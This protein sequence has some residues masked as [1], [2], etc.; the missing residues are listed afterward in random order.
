L[1]TNISETKASESAREIPRGTVTFLFTDIQG[2]TQLVHQYGDAYPDILNEHN[3]LL[4]AIFDSY[5]GYEVNTEGDS[6]FIAFTRAIDG[7]AAAAAAQSAL[8]D[9]VWPGGTTVQVRMGLHTGEPMCTGDD[10]TGLDVHRAARIG[11]AAHGG[12]ILASEPVKMLASSRL[13][14]GVAFRDMGDHKL[15]DLE[16]LEHLFQVLFPG[17]RDEFPPIRSLNNRPN[18]L[19]PQTPRMIGREKEL[20]AICERLRNPET[21]ILTLTGPGGTGKTLLALKAS[22]Q[23][24]EY[25]QDGVYLVELASISDT[26]LVPGEIARALGLRETSA[27][28]MIELL[29]QELGPKKALLVLD[30]L[31]QVLGAATVVAPLIE[32]CP[33]LHI[34]V[35]SRSPMHIRGETTFPVPPLEVPLIRPGTAVEAIAASPAVQLFEAR[36]AQVNRDFKLTNENSASVA[37]I[38]N[39]LG[40]LPLAIELAAARL[41]LLTPQSLLSRLVRKDDRLSLDLLAGGPHDSSARQ[42][43]IRS[44]IAWSYD[45]I[46]DEEV[47]NL[48][49]RLAVFAGGCTVGAAEAVCSDCASSQNYILDVIAA[50]VDMNLLRQ[51]VGADGEPRVSMFETIREFALEQLHTSG[52]APGAFQAHAEYFT[53]WLKSA[54]ADTGGGAAPISPEQLHSELEN[55][56][57]ALA[58]SLQYSPETAAQLAGAMGEVWF[59]KGEW[60]ELR[61][62]CDR[63]IKLDEITGV[64][65]ARCYR[66][67]GMC[68]EAQG[69]VPIALEL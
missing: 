64:E 59:R 57:S 8:A 41:K 33:S 54:V 47:R 43:T 45:L 23:M 13:P 52:N 58:W 29:K 61:N 15:R 9:H 6:F 27:R 24:L 28:S 38:C 65:K 35:T 2:S 10:Y 63:V 49:S 67:A 25:L 1:S 30:N 16:Q 14:P 53:Q 32:A 60:A 55:V 5:G 20:A 68:A 51:Q 56:R 62:L 4:R 42:Q 11:A 34:L 31:E 44:T 12:Q 3:S 50:L 69:D 17:G 66:Y 36:A 21:R 18:N 26:N 7:I 46:R 48:F 19:P 22:A 37:E 39:K 40:G